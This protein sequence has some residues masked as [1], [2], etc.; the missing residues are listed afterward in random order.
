MFNYQRVL[1][2]PPQMA[3]EKKGHSP[4]ICI[5]RVIF[6][7]FPGPIGRLGGDFNLRNMGV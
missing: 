3:V 6:D 5:R 1:G 4:E 2:N 7:P